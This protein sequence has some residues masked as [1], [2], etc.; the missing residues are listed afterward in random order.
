MK[1]CVECLFFP[2]HNG[3]IGK[4]IKH[5]KDVEIYAEACDKFIED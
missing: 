3:K 5:D 4:C 1:Y 2:G